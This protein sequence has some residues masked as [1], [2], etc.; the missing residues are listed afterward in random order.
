MWIDTKI[1]SVR[2]CV[3]PKMG[4]QSFHQIEIEFRMR[5]F[6]TFVRLL[7]YA[8][9]SL[10]PLILLGSGVDFAQEPTATRVEHA[11]REPRNWLTF[12]GNY[13]G[14]SYSRLKEI[15]RTNVKKLVPVWAFP[16]GFPPSSIPR[17]GLEA[18]PLVMEGVLYLEG[19][20]NNVYAIDAATGRP[21]WTYFYKLPQS[22]F[23]GARG[24]RGLAIG[25]GMIFMGTQDN[26][27]VALDLKTGAEVWNV[28]VENVFD[29]GCGVTSAPLFVRDKV[30]VGVTGGD[31]AHRGYLSAFDAS[32]GKLDWRF[33]TIPAPGEPGSETWP[34]DAWK[35]GGGATWLTGS[36]DDEL[37][38]VYWGVGNPSSDF[39]GED[40]TGLNL[41]TDSLIAL[42][43]DTGK[44]KWYFQETPHDVYDYDS[45]PE[46]VLIDIDQR[47]TSRKI[48]LHSSKNGFAYEYDRETGQFIRSFPY[49]KTITWTKGLD[50]NGKPT[51]TTIPGAVKDFH[52]CPGVGG[53]RNFNHSA[54]SPLTGWWYSTGTEMCS[55][56][57]PGKTEVRPGADWFAGKIADVANLQAQ[58][59]ISAF[60]PATGKEQWSF[61]TKYVNASSLLATAGGLIF[62]GDVEGYAFALDART[63]QKLWSFNTGGRIS[64]PPVSF[65][66]NGRQYIAIGSGGGSVNETVVPKLWP[67]SA[68][69]LP[70]S[71]STL[72]VFALPEATP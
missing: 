51:D 22:N 3:T 44:L 69:H 16:T 67:E 72:F 23:P 49:V 52:F 38:I 9:C 27:V 20:Q 68:G 43:A 71:T 36:Y 53:A 2:A 8:C 32:T 42:N 60:D 21:L 7:I 39:Y 33:Y 24:A 15:N 29:C 26:H 54:Y 25:R 35:V 19:P 47:G 12:Y 62:A 31:Q 56:L 10:T 6:R 37:N 65:S 55:T 34:G 5:R 41:Y 63:G 66:V 1:A 48:V 28:E 11:D 18:A 45:S 50:K 14:W 70:Q 61:A 46:P 59:H 4:V 13:G 64:A 57:E 58:P 17:W 30:I 40:R